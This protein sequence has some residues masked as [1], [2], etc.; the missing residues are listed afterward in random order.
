MLKN[1]SLRGRLAI[2]AIC[3]SIG[4]IL[5]ASMGILSNRVNQAALSD[6]FEND[7]ESLVRLQRVENLLLEVRFRAAGTLLDQLPI[8]GSLNHLNESRV[9]LNALWKLIQSTGDKTFDRP[10]E[11]RIYAE[12]KSNWSLVEDTLKKLEEGYRSKDKVMITTVL[13]EHWPV[14]LK[15]VVKPLQ[16]LIPLTKNGGE[17][18][19]RSAE[20][21]SKLWLQYGV[22]GG[23]VSLLVLLIV[24]YLTSDAIIGP[25]LQLEAA[26][27]D[28]S[29]GDLSQEIMSDSNDEM[30]RMLKGLEGMRK[31]LSKVVNEVRQG[32][33]LISNASSEIAYGNGDLSAR[34]ESQAS[35]LQ[36]T[37][38]SMEE[39]GSQVRHN[40]ENAR[41]ANT[42][43]LKASSVAVEG[44]DVVD[45]VVEM[46][47]GINESS[48][49]ISDIISVMDGI[50]FQTNI[51]ALNA[52]V[53][54]A[55]AGDQGLGFA[56][57][58][59][60]VR[61]LAGRSAD[62]AKEIKA[63]IT[64]SVDRVEQG[65]KLVDKAGATMHDVV[66]S[67]RSVTDI[68]GEI[69]AASVEQSTGVSQVGDAVAVMDQ[70]TQQNAALVEQMAAATATL[71]AQAD[72]LVR[73]VDTFKLEGLN[74][75]YF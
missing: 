74:L 15:A 34:T 4:I 35:A 19:F 44:G 36:Q 51:L 48:K 26:V 20:A 14:M 45:Q 43:A 27:A 39:L 60:E 73:V 53:E 52:A 56:V 47:E 75:T 12:L 1:L 29:R 23:V 10:E 38:A 22:A 59:S 61:S 24:A 28:I 57:V 72:D 8:P 9:S 66:N 69:S 70:T 40:A 2:L 31:S 16:S 30:G 37:S 55:R 33:Y 42:L 68:M 41:Q 50:A 58:A 64:A 46:M 62:A 21:A 3:G 71:K 67:I 25:V 6:L 49:R 63:L 17:K 54:A 65:T 7:T 5:V 13:E 32:S 18:S 11:A